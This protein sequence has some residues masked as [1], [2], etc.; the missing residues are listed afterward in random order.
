MVLKLRIPTLCCAFHY[1]NLTGDICADLSVQCNA[2]FVYFVTLPI[3]APQTIIENQTEWWTTEC[4]EY[5]G[6]SSLRA[7]VLQY[8][9]YSNL[10][11]K[12]S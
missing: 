11:N 8:H 3:V 12:K 2:S 7:T 10:Y 5:P 9:N 4:N 6:H 1:L